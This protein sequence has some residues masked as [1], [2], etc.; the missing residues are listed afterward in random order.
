MSCKKTI[1]WQYN[2][3]I[4]SYLLLRGKCRFCGASY[5]PRYLFVELLTGVMFV[6]F[7]AVF[8][9]TGL[10]L[11]YVIMGC[12]F[13]VATFVDFGHRIIPDEVSVGGTYAG[14][15][16]SLLIPQMH[17]ETQPVV[18]AGRVLMWSLV[19]I[20]AVGFLW[21]IFIAKRPLEKGDG[22]FFLFVG[23]F[24]S[25][26]VVLKLV[27]DAGMAAT[28]LPYLRSL[29]SSII[30]MFVSGGMIYALGVL[31]DIIFRKESMGGGDVKLMAMVGAFLGWKL[32]VLAFFIAPVFGAAFGIVEKIRTGDTTIAYGPFLVLGSLISLFWGDLIIKWIISGYGLY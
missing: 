31:G 27:L 20:L 5:S 10:Y 3:P 30:G 2:I 12:G 19:G 14:L 25:L 32:A 15:L 17:M 13:I 11:A 29:H 9:L 28:F 22:L 16:L 26:E 4:I 21:E 23:F 1:P 8:G 18:S 7:Y 6:S 24:L